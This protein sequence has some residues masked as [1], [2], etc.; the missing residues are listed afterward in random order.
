MTTTPRLWKSQTQVN[1][2]DADSQFDGQIAG[3]SDGGYV[4]VWTD[5]TLTLDDGAIFGQRY[6]SAGNKV[7]GEVPLTLSLPN[8]NLPTGS[9]FAP[10]VTV[11]PNGA[12]AVAFVDQPDSN[13]NEAVY[14]RIFDPSLNLIRQDS[15]DLT[16]NVTSNAQPSITSFVGNN[17]VVSYTAG[18]GGSPSIVGVQVDVFGTQGAPFNIH[19][20]STSEAANFS[21]LATLSNGRFVAVYEATRSYIDHDIFFGVFS[22]SG[23]LVAPAGDIDVPGGAGS[24]RETRP[25]VAALRDGGFVVVWTDPDDPNL[26]SDPTTDIRASILSNAGTAVTSNIL[27]NTTRDGAHSANVVGLRDGGFLVTWD[28]PAANLIRAQR[29]DALGHKIGGEF[30]VTDDNPATSRLGDDETPAVLADGR[31]AYAF[32]DFSSGDL[33]VAT[34]IWTT[35]WPADPHLNYFNSDGPSD[36]LWQ[37]KDGTPAIWLM[38]GTNSVG[39]GVAGSFNPG[40]TWHVKAGADFNGDDKSDI[41]WQHDGGTP[42][43]WLMDGLNFISGG[44]AGSFNPGPDWQ[45]KGTGDFNGDG[46]SDI[47]WQGADGTPAIWLMN[48]MHAVTVGAVGPFN[49][50]PSWHVEGAG[51]YNDDGRSDIL[52]QHDGGTPAIWFMDGMN[53]LGGAAAGSFNPGHDWHV[54][55]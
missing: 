52:W 47:L 1:T 12:I 6:D 17:Y 43:I 41:L 7:G 4:V 22:P 23:T 26:P 34:S 27:V 39:V 14:V 13:L 48:G 55:A 51:D 49:P 53:F 32:D 46:R 45:I 40:P 11:L 28:D 18:N 38:N 3:L 54:I 19:D 5:R 33:D 8:A 50:G 10:A 42:A 29:F 2:T 31:I 16:Q 25:D 20:T 24:R 44:V 9:R 15:I 30:T 35:R 37:G 36:I 21:E